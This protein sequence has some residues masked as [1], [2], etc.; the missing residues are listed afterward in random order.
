MCS[1]KTPLA[2]PS[3][4][5]RVNE[6][7]MFWFRYRYD[8]NIYLLSWFTVKNTESN[9]VQ[10]FLLKNKA[11]E[12]T[13]NWSRRHIAPNKNTPSSFRRSFESM[14]KIQNTNC[15]VLHQGLSRLINTILYFGEKIERGWK[16]F[17]PI[18]IPT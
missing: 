8:W 5:K 13:T 7:K 15:Q 3:C 10:I 6:F 12:M 4:K 18:I 1:N 11:G 17:R 2:L 16:K 14:A 9:P